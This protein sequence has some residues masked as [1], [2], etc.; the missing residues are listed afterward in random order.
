VQG[1]KYSRWRDRSLSRY[2]E[3]RGWLGSQ[4]RDPQNPPETRDGDSGFSWLLETAETACPGCGA[5]E[6]ESHL[7]SCKEAA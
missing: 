3:S 1:V 6:H 7:D 5:G 4:G 2:E